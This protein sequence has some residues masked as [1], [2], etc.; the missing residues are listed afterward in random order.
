MRTK[1][2]TAPTVQTSELV[3]LVREAVPSMMRACGNSYANAWL[4][5]WLTRA[6]KCGAYDGAVVGNIIE[7]IERHNDKEPPNDR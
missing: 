6:K 3:D 1:I 7:L 5:D 4:E 2:Y